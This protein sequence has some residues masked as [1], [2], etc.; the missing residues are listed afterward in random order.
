MKN[1]PLT[2]RHV[3]VRPPN[4]LSWLGDRRL[5]EAVA[6][7]LTGRSART[8]AR[9]RALGVIDDVACLT[10]LQVHA[11]GLIPHP[12]WNEWQVARDGSINYWTG[13]RALSGISP[14]ALANMVNTVAHRDELQRE[15][16]LL[17]ALVAQLQH[18]LA[19]RPA[20]GPPGAA[21]DDAWHCPQLPLPLERKSP[22]RAGLIGG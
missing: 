6:C 11:F 19:E 20:A 8:A 13:A 10:L 21:N 7:R 3:P 18:Q 15:V 4:H 5:D 2:G 9:W 17:R 16:R 22:A 1:P 14:A 12:A